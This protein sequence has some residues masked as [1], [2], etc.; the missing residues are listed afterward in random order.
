M[1]TFLCCMY[2]LLYV[3][4]SLSVWWLKLRPWTPTRTQVQLVL[5]MTHMT[6]CQHINTYLN[7]AG[8]DSP[9]VLVSTCSLFPDDLGFDEDKRESLR[10]LGRFSAALFVFILRLVCMK[11]KQCANE[12]ISSALI[13]SPQMWRLYIS[14]WHLVVFKVKKHGVWSHFASGSQQLRHWMLISGLWEMKCQFTQKAAL[15]TNISR[16]CI[17]RGDFTVKDW[18]HINT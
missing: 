3:L 18:H 13:F 8:P 5:P 1:C 4:S 7:P 14:W 15:K 17:K 10:S 11:R 2:K 12:W 16:F 6:N 9:A